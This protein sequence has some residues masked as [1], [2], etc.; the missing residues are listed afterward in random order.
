MVFNRSYKDPRL[1][2]PKFLFRGQSSYWVTEHNDFILKA[3]SEK[4]TGVEMIDMD[5]L[6]S[7]SCSEFSGKSR[8]NTPVGDSTFIIPDLVQKSNTLI[9]IK[10]SCL[11]TVNPIQ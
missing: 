6:D 3:F 4:K 11:T 8:T 2:P 7:E 9:P 1:D 5:Y 10:T